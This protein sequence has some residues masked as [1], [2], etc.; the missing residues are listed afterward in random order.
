MHPDQRL[1][2]AVKGFYA[3]LG[4]VVLAMVSPP[5]A[6]SLVHQHSIGPRVLGVV[7]GVG[8]WVPLMVLVAYIIR[9]S[10]EFTQRIHYLALSIAFG[11]GF[12]LIAALDWLVRA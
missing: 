2:K 9:A 4:S 1:R 3:Y 10:D 7:L 11:F 6:S 12:V 5:I 8:G